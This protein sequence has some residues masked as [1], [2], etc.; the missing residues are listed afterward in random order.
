[1]PCGS[2]RCCCSTRLTG[3]SRSPHSANSSRARRLLG[4]PDAVFADDADGEV[5]CAC[6]R[7]SHLAHFDLIEGTAAQGATVSGS[8]S[9]WFLP[10][11]GESIDRPGRG[12]IGVLL[13]KSAQSASCLH[14]TD[15]AENP[16]PLPVR[17]LKSL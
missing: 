5:L 1:M 9:P 17:L 14:A 10:A 15:P 4:R 7:S 3:E 13:R 12:R 2:A 6:P 11:A 16:A 8:R